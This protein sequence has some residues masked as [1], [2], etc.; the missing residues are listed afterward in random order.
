MVPHL[1]AQ[2][3]GL[4]CHVL[5]CLSFRQGLQ[6]SQCSGRAGGGRQPPPGCGVVPCHSLG[7]VP[8]S[9]PE[10][11]G[12]ALKNSTLSQLGNL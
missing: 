5:P 10:A 1:D 8:P 12:F 11:M 4:P 2:L 3:Y 7:L 6:H 9:D